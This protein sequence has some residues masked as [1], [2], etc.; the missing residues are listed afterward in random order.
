MEVAG[1]TVVLGFTVVLIVEIILVVLPIKVT[2]VPV[3]S[4]QSSD[5]IGVSIVDRLDPQSRSKGQEIGNMGGR[6]W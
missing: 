3:K 5:L 4:D 1:T 2:V 6:S